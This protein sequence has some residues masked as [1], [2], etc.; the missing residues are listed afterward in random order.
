M[1]M[2]PARAS[3]AG[4]P[5]DG[6][7]GAVLAVPIADL[8]AIASIEESDEFSVRASDADLHR[9]L[10]AVAEEFVATVGP[11]DG[12]TLSATTTIPRS[13]GLAGSSAIVIAALRSL[14]ATNRHTWRPVDLAATALRVEQDR[15]GIT[16]GLQDRLV[17]SVGAT[18]AMEF[19]PVGFEQIACPVDLPLFV[20]WSVD[21]AESSGTVHRSIRRRFDG[22]DERVRATM[23]ELAAQARAAAAA[24]STG[25]LRDVAAAMN[26]TFDLRARM[27]DIDATTRSLAGIGHDCG[28]AINS[29]GSGGAIV[30]LVP[31][32]RHLDDVAD[33][34]RSAGYGFLEVG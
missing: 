9:L 16:A 6:Y 33:A 17:Q 24:I 13:V 22:G 21:G 4:N 34:Y 19:D 5:S 15:L 10:T 3:L 25:D 27:L 2:C 29:A 8:T 7:G 23:T 14:A 28:A 26:R 1:N 18:I 11:I 31:T 20:A 12:G 30:G 32:R